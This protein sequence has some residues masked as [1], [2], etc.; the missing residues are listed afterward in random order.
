MFALPP[1]EPWMADAV[2]ASTDAELFFPEKGGTPQLAKRVCAGCP[3]REKCLAF[4]LEHGDLGVWGG[5]TERER[6][7]IRKESA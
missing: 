7:L 4:A 2:C 1:P 5:T 6:R 3:V